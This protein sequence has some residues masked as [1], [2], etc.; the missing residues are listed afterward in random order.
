VPEEKKK[1]EEETPLID[2]AEDLTKAFFQFARATVKAF[3]KL[4]KEA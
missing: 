4:L 1:V 2:L 3:K